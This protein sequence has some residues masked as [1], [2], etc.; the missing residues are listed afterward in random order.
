MGAEG[1]GAEENWGFNPFEDLRLGD[2]NRT[3]G[4][5]LLPLPV[6]KRQ[7]EDQRERRKW[8]E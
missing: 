4:H 2:F 5:W 7:V 6:Q 3:Q 1:K 8:K